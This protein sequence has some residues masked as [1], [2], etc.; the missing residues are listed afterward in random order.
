MSL[1]CQKEKW[2][3]LTPST[4]PYPFG[5]LNLQ[6]QCFRTCH[7]ASFT[8][9]NILELPP[10][11]FMLSWIKHTPKMRNTPKSDICLTFPSLSGI[12]KITKKCQK[13]PTY[14]LQMIP[15]FAEHRELMLRQD[16]SR[17]GYEAQCMHWVLAGCNSMFTPNLYFGAY[18][19]T[20]SRCDLPFTWIICR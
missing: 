6:A 20:M 17:I 5:C 12:R 15:E 19:S 1:Y 3:I 4:L 14:Y 7:Y 11:F 16:S 18:V 10:S 2:A 13:I 9:H 8:S